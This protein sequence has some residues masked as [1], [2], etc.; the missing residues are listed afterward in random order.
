MKYTTQCHSSGYRVFVMLSHLTP[1]ALLLSLGSPSNV[2]AITP[3]A[4]FRVQI[5]KVN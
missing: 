3:E 5:K 1:A 4:Y 2:L